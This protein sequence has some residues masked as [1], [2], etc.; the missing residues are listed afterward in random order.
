MPGFNEFT[1]PFAAIRLLGGSATAVWVVRGV[2]A[3]LAI[4]GT[5]R[6]SATATGRR[7]EIAMLVVATG[8]CVPFLGIYDVVLFM[9]AG[10][11]L[12]SAA[13][14]TGWLP[15]ERV[16]LFLLYLSPIA[17]LVL[18]TRGIPLA[19]VG[20]AILAALVVRRVFRTPLLSASVRG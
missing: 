12:V 11:W 15:Y 3:A 6:G 13:D 17:I 20:L 2:F 1:R 4:V 18:M 8:F 7:G 16:A 19:P 5:H 9:V 10:A 14:H